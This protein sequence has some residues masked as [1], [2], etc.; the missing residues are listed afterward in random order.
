[1][2]LTDEINAKVREHYNL[3]KTIVEES[4]EIEE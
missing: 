2:D 4:Q 3:D 1:M